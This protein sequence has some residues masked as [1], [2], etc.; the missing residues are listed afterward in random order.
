MNNKCSNSF[1]DKSHLPKP[2]IDK[3]KVV[4]PVRV[5]CLDIYDNK[6]M[7]GIGHIENT[8]VEQD[9][10]N[11]LDCFKLYKRRNRK[12]NGDPTQIGVD[13]RYET[14]INALNNSY[15]SEAIKIVEKEEI[16]PHYEETYLA[17]ITPDEKAGIKNLSCPKEI[18]PEEGKLVFWPRDDSYWLI[19]SYEETEK[20]FFKGTIE[21]CN[22]V[23][24]WRDEHGNIYRQRVK[25][26]GPVETKY[27]N[28]NLGEFIMGKANETNTLWMANTEQTR[29]LKRYKKLIIN[30]KGYNISVIND[31]SSIIEIQLIEGYI[32]PDEDTLIAG[33]ELSQ[34]QLEH[35]YDVYTSIDDIKELPQKP[36]KFT[37]VLYKNGQLINIMPNIT[38][39]GNAT[40]DIITG[41][42]TPLG[43]G[44]III[45]VCYPGY[46]VGKTYEI[47]ILADQEI[48]A[49]Y[50]ILGP[51]SISMYG[52]AMY[53]LVR[54]EGGAETPV[55]STLITIDTLDVKKATITSKAEDSI[56]IT[57]KKISKFKIFAL[58]DDV[59]IE[60]EIQII[61]PW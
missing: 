10:T 52:N 51:D 59:K 57:P 24:T 32:N 46:P 43:E 16:F 15:N 18:L 9:L 26:Q 25:M 13:E 17:L 54:N 7:A 42:I 55:D 41:M 31:V 22:Y 11:T 6:V 27:K 40:Y 60:R 39:E 50:E 61:S 48:K 30:G 36:F 21:K 49:Y 12:M 33:E 5:E 1:N 35:D 28:E 56:I 53:R 14:F 44:K 2:D 29:H 38:I 3:I 8:I 23:L 34:G 37:T 19:T 47:N 45:K 58:V 20:A 4:R